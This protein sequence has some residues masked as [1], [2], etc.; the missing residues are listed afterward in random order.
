MSGETGLGR[1][2]LEQLFSDLED[3]LLGAGDHQRLMAAMRHDP[4]VRRAYLEH[5]GQ[6]SA[7]HEVAK[8]WAELHGGDLQRV[9]PDTRRQLT[10]SLLA[11]AALLA[12]LAVIAALVIPKGPEPAMV[13]SGP[14]TEWRFEAGGLAED[15]R[16]MAD[17]RFRVERGTLMVRT[18]RGSEI[19]LEGPA[20]FAMRDS[21]NGE[22]LEGT[23]W[24]RVAE[25]D[26]GFTVLTPRV[27]VVDLGTEFGLIVRP[28]E[29]QVHVGSGRV[30]VSSRFPG[31]PGR[32]LG[33][34]EAVDANE[35]GRL[36]AVDFDARL[37]QRELPDAPRTWHWSFDREAGR[38]EYPVEAVGELRRAE[39]R[40]GEAFDAAATGGGCRSDFPGIHGSGARTVALW[41][42]GRP[43]EQPLADDGRHVQPTL[44]GWGSYSHMG[45]KWDV[46]TTPDG[47]EVA[48]QWGGSWI[49]SKLPAGASLLDGEWHHVVSVFTGRHLE[50]EP[51][52]RHYVDGVSLPNGPRHIESSVR[53][54]SGPGGVRRTMILRHDWPG[55]GGRSFP[56]AIDELYVIRHPLGLAGVRGL[57]EE[58]RLDFEVADGE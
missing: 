45:T 49:V 31:V 16:L 10:R 6:A 40:W 24:F 17:T 1:K 4:S 32:E 52:I 21:S 29:G 53:T 37:F 56:W 34:G 57:F 55:Y 22:L 36:S 19:L 46:T 38:E 30:E 8:G 20:D 25:G 58:N 2:E 47:R 42:K 7:L 9:V 3:G 50:G 12:L 33:A 5:M 54:S 51:E 11:A 15:G 23:G 48:T 43:V 35:V 13:A 44:V 39:G 27:R 14:G 18:G 41:V 28:E 26:E